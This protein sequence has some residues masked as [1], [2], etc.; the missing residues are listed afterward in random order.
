[1]EYNKTEV[2]ETQ[3]T[4]ATNPATIVVDKPQAVYNTKKTIFRLYQVIWYIL[5]VI[6][7]LLAFRFI[8]KLLGANMGSGFVNLI[9][10]LT[11]PFVAPFRGVLGATESGM[12]IF[13]WSVIF[14]GI[15]YFILAYAIIYFMQLVKPTTPDEVTQVVDNT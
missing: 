15:V 14:A 6:E 2:V 5:G 1:M 9:Y 7:V 4:T 11:G 8:L 10:S 13:E 3:T 12:I